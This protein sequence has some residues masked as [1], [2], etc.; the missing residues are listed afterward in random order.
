MALNQGFYNLFLAVG[1]LLGVAFLAAGGSLLGA[2]LAMT[3]LSVGSMLAAALVLVI[4]NPR[5]ARAA[6]TQGTLPLIAV[7][8]VTVGALTR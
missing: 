1:A 8:L 6:A 2:G 5:L 3:L 7:L 4:S